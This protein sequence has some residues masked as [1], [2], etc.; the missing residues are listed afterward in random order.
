MIATEAIEAVGDESKALLDH[1]NGLRDYTANGLIGPWSWGAPR[2]EPGEGVRRGPA[3]CVV[4]I[5]W[6]GTEYETA[7]A[8]EGG[9]I[10]CT[11]P[12]NSI[13][14]EKP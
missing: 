4:P 7:K 9:K 6:N 1:M 3:R 11:E 2:D 5:V 13:T 14:G 10:V 8:S 12:I